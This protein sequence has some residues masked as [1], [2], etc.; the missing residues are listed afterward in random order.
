MKT[1]V[2]GLDGACWHMLKPWIKKGQLPGFQK[3]IDEGA[4]GVLE[5][6]PP[7]TPPAWTS[8]TTG[9]SLEKHGLYSFQRID[10][11]YRLTPQ[12]NRHR[13][14]R[15]WDFYDRP[16]VLNVPLTYPVYD[17]Q[18]VMVSG[19]MS[20][21]LNE[22]TAHPSSELD[23]L[24]KAGYVIEPE[25]RYPECEKSLENRI[26]VARHYLEKDYDFYFIV[27]REFDPVQHYF[28]DKTLDMYQ[29]MDGFLQEVMRDYPDSTLYLVSDHGFRHINNLFVVKNWL[30]E[31]G[32]LDVE[33]PTGAGL[34]D[35]LKPLARRYYL[36]RF[37][38]DFVKEFL[39][40][41]S[42]VGKIDYKPRGETTV[43]P[44]GWGE[45]YVNSKRR[46]DDGIIEAGKE[47]KV[48]EKLKK[49]M[50]DF[51]YQGVDVLKH[52][53]SFEDESLPDLMFFPNT[54]QGISSELSSP[55]PDSVVDAKS[56]GK[57][58]D[59]SDDALMACWGK[60]VENKKFEA[61]ILDF[62]PTVLKSSGIEKTKN[63]DGRVLNI[64]K[65]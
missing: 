26:Q 34:I 24:E 18:G 38:P 42:S 14:K 40:N 43:F 63:M 21:Q 2:F 61:S 54:N 44:G 22:K 6:I 56:K 37:I 7:L 10:R 60:D 46:F 32:Y 58:G 1:I 8:L 12:L 30:R 29:L 65:P 25:V 4:H 55:Y 15:I 5:S 3:I 9:L 23:Y 13:N 27:F 50:E 17:N 16:C 47:K 48:R 53:L 45:L 64:F 49:E 39:S 62:A 28:W 31:N 19:M 51:S 41:R 11:N 33:E 57:T 20:P 36:D 35:R 52:V 59:H